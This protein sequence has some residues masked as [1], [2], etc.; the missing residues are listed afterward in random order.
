[1][2]WAGGKRVGGEHG[3]RENEWEGGVLRREARECTETG[4][5]QS[6]GIMRGS[7]NGF[8]G[9]GFV[10]GGGEGGV[11]RAVIVEEGWMWARARQ[12]KESGGGSREGGQ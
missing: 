11:S 5:I 1:V 8:G 9:C 3:R 12:S 4:A 10:R 7:E 6:K 2:V